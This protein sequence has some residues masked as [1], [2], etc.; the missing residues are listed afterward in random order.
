M[1]QAPQE[2][3]QRKKISAK[4]FIKIW[5]GD[6]KGV[7]CYEEYYQ[8]N[9]WGEQYVVF[10]NFIIDDVNIENERVLPKL[11]LK[12]ITIDSFLINNTSG[13]FID[14][15]NTVID[16]FQIESTTID[17]IILS[18]STIRYMSIEYSSLGALRTDLS[19]LKK[20]RIDNSNLYIINL[21]VS[22]FEYI[23]MNKSRI[24]DIRIS[25]SEIIRYEI[26]G[27]R[28]K[29]NSIYNSFVETIDINGVK[30]DI[31][32]I[33]DA[34]IKTLIVDKAIIEDVQLK[35]CNFLSVYFYSFKEK[36][37]NLNI[38]SC[39]ITVLHFLMDN[40]NN[41]V[42]KSF[43]KNSIRSIVNKL[44]LNQSV[45]ANDT[46]LQI[47]ET[48]IK[49]L[50][51]N[52]LNNKGRIVFN[53]IKALRHKYIFKILNS[54]ATENYLFPY[55]AVYKFLIIKT[56][57]YLKIK[58]DICIINSDLGDTQ[59][60]GC[61]LSDFES[62]IFKNSKMLEVFLAD[63]KLPHAKDINKNV[64]DSNEQRRL[65][66][67]QF[68]KVYENQGDTVRALEMR[69]QEMEVY[70][71]LLRENKEIKNRNVERFNLFL[72]RWS[73]YYGTNW[74]LAT[75]MTMAMVWLFFSAYCWAI[76]YRFGDDMEQFWLLFSHSFEFLNPIRKQ[77]SFI[78]EDKVTPL[79]RIIDYVGRIFISYMVYQTIQ[80]F[81]KF[82]KK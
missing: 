40:F 67:G 57:V 21:R 79:A 12:N 20:I 24:D 35:S 73:N 59:F 53:D 39:D 66:L 30:V 50:E 58:S 70:R 5:R 7:E 63:T 8:R 34:K 64:K 6:Y 3:P 46:N 80:A 27:G 32:R 52:T 60:I 82:G 4:E 69:A 31:L 23:I 55:S 48:D 17:N 15:E 74:L 25:D 16:S 10:D 38:S 77:P 19:D 65:A 9:Y 49:S 72:N 36:S 2:Q 44:V 71:Q 13:I 68:K 45:I 43:H 78:E 54:T 56:L 75:G 14:I 26:R 62:F 18:N 51:F 76:G 22:D 41:V 61:D 29:E 33:L 1:N 47:S 11:E 42:I 28:F 37:K 81:R